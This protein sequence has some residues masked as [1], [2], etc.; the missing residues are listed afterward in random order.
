MS[1]DFNNWYEHPERAELR[2]S[3]AKGWANIIWQSSRNNVEVDLPIGFTYHGS[4]NQ[5]EY[6]FEAGAVVSAIEATGVK[7]KP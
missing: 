5:T 4:S 2:M 3:C 1:E 6:V 7:V